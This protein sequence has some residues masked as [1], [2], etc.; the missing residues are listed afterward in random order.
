MSY[1]VASALQRREGDGGR[2][3]LIA[4]F[5]DATVCLRAAQACSKRAVARTGRGVHTCACRYTFGDG[6]AHWAESVNAT[7]K[8]DTENERET[9]DRPLGPVVHDKLFRTVRRKFTVLIGRSF[10]ITLS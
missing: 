6:I 10:R 1:M 3:T 8:N 7:Q 4:A 2:S 9:R 5:L